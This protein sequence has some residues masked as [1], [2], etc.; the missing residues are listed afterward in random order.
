MNLLVHISSWFLTLVLVVWLLRAKRAAATLSM[1]PVIQSQE[2]RNALSNTEGL[3]T[4]IVPAKNEEK[5]IRHCIQSLLSQDYPNFEIIA[6]NDGSRDQ[7]EAI[8]KSL[9]AENITRNPGEKTGKTACA[10]LRYLN[11]KPT[12]SGWTGKNFAI[13]QAVREARGDW[14]LFTDADT[15]HSP[16][17]IS[18]AMVHIHERNLS[19]LTL[20]PRSLTGSFPEDLIQPSAMAFLG[21][22]F[23][24]EKI[25]DPHSPVYFANGQYLLM[26]RALYEALGGHEKV[27]GAFL[28]D[29]ALMKNAKESGAKTE[30]ALGVQVYGTRMYDSFRGIWAGWRRIYLHA[31]QSHFRTLIQKSLEVLFFSVLPVP[32]SLILL[33]QADNTLL[34]RGLS[35]LVP[36]LILGIAWKSYGI[37][38]A[39]KIFA[40]GHPIAAFFISL[41]IAEAAW[42]AVTKRKTEWR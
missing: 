11:S 29:F 23:P 3:V 8:L 31:F 28:E 13:H 26:K 2:S 15:R 33:F 36:T 35:I 20:L 42:M 21:L 32:L 24:I 18:L 27:Q 9:G 22:W 12:P 37:I 34:I 38:K 4:V 17:S 5:N 14:Y 39:K 7:T 10:R 1:M 6:V 16:A 30:C 25:N 19:L 41:M 40:F